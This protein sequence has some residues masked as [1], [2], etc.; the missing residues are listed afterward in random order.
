MVYSAV[1]LFIVDVIYGLESSDDLMVMVCSAWL[2]VAGSKGFSE[3]SG[4]K[5]TNAV[6]FG[7]R[8]DDLSI[9]VAAQ[10]AVVSCTMHVIA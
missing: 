1:I 10:S 6:T 8:S 9:V 7:K 3:F 2:Q 5:N 4:I